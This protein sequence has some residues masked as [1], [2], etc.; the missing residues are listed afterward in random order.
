[1]SP[2]CISFTLTSYPTLLIADELCGSPT[3]NAPYTDITNPEQSV[4]FVKLDPPYTY[5]FPTNCAA[6]ATT[7][8]PPLPLGALYDADE[9]EL[10]EE[11]LD[12]LAVALAAAAAAA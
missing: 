11:L 10:L 5:G 3:P 9:L 6:Y 12:D 7:A 8:D 4:P 1:M 2:G